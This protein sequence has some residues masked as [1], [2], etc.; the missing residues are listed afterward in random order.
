M[1]STH[2]LSLLSDELSPDWRPLRIWFFIYIINITVGITIHRGSLTH[3]FSG[4]NNS[5]ISTKR[6]AFIA[7]SYVAL[8]FC[9][10]LILSLLA[11][12]QLHNYLSLWQEIH[13]VPDYIVLQSMATLSVNYFHLAVEHL[14]YK[15]AGGNPASIFAN[16]LIFAITFVSLQSV[17]LHY[18]VFTSDADSLNLIRKQIMNQ[19]LI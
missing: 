1:D 17:G 3:L 2:Q 11:A 5:F 18:L 13:Y 12:S 14:V 16:S 4:I 10:M 6:K 8:E 19:H 9:M 7:I 15:T